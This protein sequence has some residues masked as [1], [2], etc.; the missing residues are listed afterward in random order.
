MSKIAVVYGTSNGTT[1]EVAKKIHGLLSNADLYNVEDISVD[2]LEPYDFLIFGT[3]TT[4]IGDLL[5]EWDALLPKLEKADWSGKKIALF[6]LGDSAS[7]STSYAEGMYHIYK[8][9]K[10]KVEFVGA[11]S[12]D[13]YTFDESQ[14]VIDGKFIGLALDEDNEYDKTDERIKDWLADLKQYLN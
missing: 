11:V 5:D 6:G 10:G 13:G 14:A 1:E 3:S 7:F 8:P 12:T 9:L 4:G 2:R